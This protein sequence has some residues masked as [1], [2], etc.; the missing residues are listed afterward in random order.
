MAD[1]HPAANRGVEEFGRALAQRDRVGV[2]AERIF[3]AGKPGGVAD[4]RIIRR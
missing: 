2:G 1:G 4:A 3:A